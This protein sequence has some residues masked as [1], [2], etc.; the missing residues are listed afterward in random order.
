[1]RG[2]PVTH[3]SQPT[4]IFNSNVER[5]RPVVTFGSQA[6]SCGELLTPRDREPIHVGCCWILLFWFILDGR[7]EFPGCR[8]NASRQP[9]QFLYMSLAHVV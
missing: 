4:R 8:P 6:D 3:Q 5:T 9:E 2:D 7:G 1:M